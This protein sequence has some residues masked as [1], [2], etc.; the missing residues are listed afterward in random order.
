MK[1]GGQRDQ[2]SGVA[3]GHGWRSCPLRNRPAPRTSK[4]A[5]P[6]QNLQS[7]LFAAVWIAEIHFRCSATRPLFSPWGSSAKVGGRGHEGH[8]DRWPS[9][10]P[11]LQRPP[12][13]PYGS[14]TKLVGPLQTPFS[15]SASIRGS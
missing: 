10:S 11:C 14:C 4:A 5:A 15:F 7:V 8:E 13:L 12:F 3:G 2:A 9:K 1:L 6:W